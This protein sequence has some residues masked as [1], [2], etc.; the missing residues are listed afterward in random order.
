MNVNEPNRSASSSSAATARARTAP[1]CP[2]EQSLVYAADGHLAELLRSLR[3]LAADSPERQAKIEGLMRAY[4]AGSLQ[5][6]AEATAGA[7]VDDATSS[8][9]VLR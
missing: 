3:S 1:V 5:I 9:W 4:A 7:I 8:R 2:P 6:D